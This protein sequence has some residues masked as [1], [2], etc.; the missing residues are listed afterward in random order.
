MKNYQRI[1]DQSSS[2]SD[3]VH[4]S[5]QKSYHSFYTEDQ[6]IDEDEL[7]KARN[8]CETDAERKALF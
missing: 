6:D 7:R 3:S 8:L 1:V 5:E 2:E 4:S